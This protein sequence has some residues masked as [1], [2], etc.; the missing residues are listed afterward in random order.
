M[1]TLAAATLQRRRTSIT[2][3]GRERDE[4]SNRVVSPQRLGHYRGNR[5]LD[6]WCHRIRAL[7]SFS[8]DRAK[9]AAGLA[10][11]AKSISDSELDSHFGEAYGIFAGEANETAVLR[12]TPALAR[13][14]VDETWHPKHVGATRADGS[15]ELRVL[16]GD[17]RELVMDILRYGSD[18]E[19]LEPEALRR[20]LRGGS[21]G[22]R[23]LYR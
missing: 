8:V 14:V 22:A 3:H 23:G 2:Y 10:D 15:Y 4:V 16:Y 7:R 13:W 21:G 11:P 17:H 1:G 20:R 12:F 9:Q 6:A 5:Y 18:V 19:V